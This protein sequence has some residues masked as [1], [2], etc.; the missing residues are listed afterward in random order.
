MCITKSEHFCRLRMPVNDNQS[1]NCKKHIALIQGVKS[2]TG[3]GC[4]GEMW[5]TP[6]GTSHS[7]ANFKL[8]KSSIY[9]L[10]LKIS[11]EWQKTLFPTSLHPSLPPGAERAW[12][13]A[14]VGILT[15][16]HPGHLCR[17]DPPVGWPHTV[18]AAEAQLP[19]IVP[20]KHCPAENC[21]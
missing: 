20:L 5:D 9:C 2:R 18:D 6:L 16:L 15:D 17:A 10:V 12:E 14:D 3:V 4:W 13:A 21:S 7:S 1:V 19:L 11:T 8:L